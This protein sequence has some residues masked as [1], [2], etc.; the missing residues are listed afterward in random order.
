MLLCDCL[1]VAI[2]TNLSFSVGLGK[3]IMI[4]SLI[5]SNRA[6]EVDD[7]EDQSDDE[8]RKGAERNG[9]NGIG[10]YRQTSLASAF[11][12]SS[13]KA[14]FASQAQRRKAML[15]SSMPRGKATLV[16]APMSLLSQWRDEL[17]RACGSELSVMLYYAESKGDL[18]GRLEGGAVDVVVT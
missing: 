15:R 3:T 6:P 1:C 14:E 17:E 2:L 4:A 7:A 9:T 10:S 11:A 13:S 16:V 18:V 12:A 5:H 8:N